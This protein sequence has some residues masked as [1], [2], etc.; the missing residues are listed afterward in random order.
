ML[1]ILDNCEHVVDACAHIADILLKK[2]LHLKILTTS[3]EVLGIV[4]E[5]VYQVP[6]LPL[7]DMRRLLEGFTEEC[8]QYLQ[9]ATSPSTP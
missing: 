9:V 4:G 2:C 7:P 6:S 1:L 8:Q 5:A 3:R